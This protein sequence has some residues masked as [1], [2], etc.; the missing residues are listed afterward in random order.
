MRTT[1]APRL[2]RRSLRTMLKVISFLSFQWSDGHGYGHANGIIDV[3]VH[4]DEGVSYPFAFMEINPYGMSDPCMFSYHEL[5]D[6]APEPEIRYRKTSD[7]RKL[8]LQ[9]GTEGVLV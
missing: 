4:Q 9:N 6:R 1:A 5:E 7:K 3:F 8:L 2:M